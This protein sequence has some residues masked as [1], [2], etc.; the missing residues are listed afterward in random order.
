MWTCTFSPCAELRRY[1]WLGLAALVVQWEKPDVPP[2]TG[3]FGWFDHLPSH[4]GCV[5]KGVFFGRRVVWA[6]LPCPRQL[7][8]PMERL[9]LLF[10]FKSACCYGEKGSVFLT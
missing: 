7:A 8:L 1:R 10:I 5:P 3:H 9:L 6:N 2:L 4:V